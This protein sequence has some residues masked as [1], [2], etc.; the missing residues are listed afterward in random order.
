MK[1]IINFYRSDSELMNDAVDRAVVE[2]YR[3]KNEEGKKSFV[4][5]GVSSACGTTTNAINIAIAL[6]VS[7]WNTALI[8]CDIRKSNKYKRI[9]K[10]V[11]KGLSDY[12][13]DDIPLDSI[14]YSTG[15]DKLTYIPRG[16]AADSPIR[17]LCSPKMEALL[18]EIYEEY[19]FVIIDTPSVNAVSDAEIIMPKVDGI[20]LVLGMSNSGK[21]QLKNAKEKIIPYESKYLGLLVN[22]VKMSDYKKA[23]SDFDYFTQNNL[24][25]QLKFN[26]RR[27]RK[28]K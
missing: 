2:I 12:L 21:K 17:L 24:D 4:L 10:S 15:Y 13:V 26:M 18:E 23:I 19:D 28:G 3:R 1:K 25:R 5:T 11:D 14:K 8:D 7:G 9:G 22:Q 16:G 27:Q 6:A 20:I